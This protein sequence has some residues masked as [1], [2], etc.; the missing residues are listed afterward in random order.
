MSNPQNAASVEMR[1]MNAGDSTLSRRVLKRCR[2]SGQPYETITE[3]I[4]I[5]RNRYG[6]QTLGYLVPAH[7][8]DEEKATLERERKAEAE[9]QLKMLAA[10]RIEKLKT[11]FPGLSQKKLNQLSESSKRVV[12]AADTGYLS[13]YGT[14]TYWRSLGYDVTTPDI[15]IVSGKRV[16]DGYSKNRLTHRPI[17]LSVTTLEKRWLSRF[18]SS[19]LVLANAVRLANRLQ[20]VVTLKEFYPLKDRWIQQN[21]HLLVDGRISRVEERVC[22]GCDGSGDG[23]FGDECRRCDGTG[24]YASR[25]LYEHHFEVEGQKFCFHSYQTPH[26]LNEKPGENLKVYGKPFRQD[27]LPLPSQ[28][29]IVA[30]IKHLMP[31]K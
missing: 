17:R 3:M 6:S 12:S 1:K 4:Q 7:V 10:E 14:K 22:F 26:V 24:I 31:E 18:G 19:E 8:L 9:K 13:G 20:K 21:Q 16:V 30:L 25:K 28:L 23:F 2:T 15:W 5:G 11:Q 29:L 27:E